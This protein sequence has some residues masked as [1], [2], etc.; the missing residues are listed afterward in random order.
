MRPSIS[1]PLA[2][3][4]G[5]ALAVP[6]DRFATALQ[7]REALGTDSSGDTGISPRGDAS[8]VGPGRDHPESA[9]GRCGLPDL[10]AGGSRNVKLAVLPFENLTGDPG[11]ITSRMA[12]PR[13]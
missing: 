12:S 3:V 1:L 11:R 6:A 10:P 7:L 4:I 5:K 13:R 9:G 8:P 2:G